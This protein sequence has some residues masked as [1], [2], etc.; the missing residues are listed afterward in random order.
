[1][2]TALCKCWHNLC[3]RIIHFVK[4]T[5]NTKNTY[6]P[7]LDLWSLSRGCLVPP[8]TSPYT[9]ARKHTEYKDLV[10]AIFAGPWTL[11]RKEYWSMTVNLWSWDLRKL[12]WYEMTSRNIR[13][14]VPYKK[15]TRYTRSHHNCWHLTQTK[16]GQLST[17]HL[18]LAKEIIKKLTNSQ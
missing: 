17:T 9:A 3:T 7:H 13:K 18:M 12:V 6:L 5:Y 4:L 16:I 8:H 15:S 14:Q 11:Q 1:M 2:H 10:H